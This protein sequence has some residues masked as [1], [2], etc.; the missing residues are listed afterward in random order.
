[1]P[2]KYMFYLFNDV[3][4]YGTLEST[5][6]FDLDMTL[7]INKYAKALESPFPVIHVYFGHKPL[8]A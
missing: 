7:P 2:S 3:L 4:L 1:M 5:G 8:Q 6:E